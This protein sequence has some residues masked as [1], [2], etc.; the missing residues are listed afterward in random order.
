M[1]TAAHS[2]G[3]SAGPS[4]A[5]RPL[6]VDVVGECLIELLG[7]GADQ[8]TMRPAGD[9]FNTASIL[10]RA[11]RALR[12]PSEVAYVTGLG[13]DPLS[14]TIAQALADH[15]LI[16]ASVRV[17]G[18][19]C[20]L[21]LLDA[22]SGAMWYWRSDSAARELFRGADW[23]PDVT[24]DLAF[25]SLITV[26][27][28]SERCRDATT[29]WLAAIRARGATVAFSLNYRAVGWPSSDDAR[30][31]AQPFINGADMVLASSGDCRALLDSADPRSALDR[32]MEIG[33]SEAVVTAGVDGAFL[34]DRETHH[35]VPTGPPDRVI[36]PTGAG[37]AFAGTY[38]AWRLAGRPPLDAARAAVRVASATVASAGALPGRGSAEDRAIDRALTDVSG[39]S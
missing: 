21:Y 5:G 23:I 11:C 31:A 39:D 27:Q 6:L 17:T 34:A 1:A 29:G 4:P 28:M 7:N 30:A 15:G 32:L 20:G 19:S 3:S 2:D 8:L 9:T 13:D 37:D 24:P 16:D 12:M 33:A 36:D 38:V 14:D 18:R 35:R 10:A 26:Q 25:L 22:A